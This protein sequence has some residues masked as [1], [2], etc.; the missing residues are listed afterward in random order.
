MT[1]D[2]YRGGG[3]SI[4]K[5]AF[6]ILVGATGLVLLAPITLLTAALVRISLGSPI[7]FRQERPGLNGQPFEVLKFRTMK[8]DTLNQG[9]ASDQ[10]RITPMGQFIRR[11]SLDEIPQLWSILKGDMSLVGP[12][13]LL[14]EYLP[15]YSDRQRMRHLVKPGLTGLAQVNGRN[16]ASWVKRFEMDVWYVENWSFMLDLKILVKTVLVVVSGSGVT[17]SGHVTVEPFRG[18]KHENEIER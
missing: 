10:A 15:L 2:Q 9:V 11:C 6:D 5:R 1:S 8:Q 18:N 4:R 17:G 13:P 3:L 14:T 16:Q 7:V 12:R